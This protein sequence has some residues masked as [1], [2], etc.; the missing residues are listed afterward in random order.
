MALGE[1][2]DVET[3]RHVDT[4][5]QGSN[6]GSSWCHRDVM[7]QE[8]LT[9]SDWSPLSESCFLDRITSG[10]ALRDWPSCSPYPRWPI[11][12]CDAW[13]PCVASPGTCYAPLVTTWPSI[14]TL[15]PTCRRKRKQHATWW[16]II[17]HHGTQSWPLDVHPSWYVL[18]M[19]RRYDQS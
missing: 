8:F 5:G 1:F 16:Q 11:A 12:A 17:A 7:S 3:V 18:T 9:I 4:K 2:D 15:M 6:M 19:I 14:Q 10:D 13:A